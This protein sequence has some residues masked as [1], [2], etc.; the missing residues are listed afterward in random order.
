MI[1]IISDTHDNV[2]NI[3]KAVEIFKKNKVEFVIHAGDIIAP[4]SVNYFEGLK[5]KFVFGNCDGDRLM[6]EEKVRNIGGEHHGR[7]MELK[8]KGKKLGVFHGDDILMNDKM[9]NAGYDYYIH[10]HTHFPEDK[11]QGNTRVLCPGGHYMGDP[12]E[13]NKVIL[14]DVAKDKVVFVDVV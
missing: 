9:M 7:T 14:L 12:K 8:F 3:K 13:Q 10:G 2:P 11:K 5:M 4:V 1:G 6:I